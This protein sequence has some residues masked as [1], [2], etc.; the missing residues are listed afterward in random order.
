M[1]DGLALVC[2]E[3]DGILVLV[4]HNI[5]SHKTSQALY[6]KHTV[7]TQRLEPYLSWKKSR[8]EGEKLVSAGT[9]RKLPKENN[10]THCPIKSRPV[11]EVFFTLVQETRVLV[12]VGV[13]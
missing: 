7:Q 3:T 4:H 10:R 2:L 6:L 13:R 8:T 5:Y 11:K 12:E 9:K 1:R